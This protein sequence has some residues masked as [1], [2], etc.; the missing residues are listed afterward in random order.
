MSHKINYNSRAGIIGIR[1][2]GKVPL[3]EFRDIYFQ[4]V[5]L[6]KEKDCFLF[7]S[8][9]RNATTSHLTLLEISTLPQTLSEIAARAGIDAKRLKRAI[10][11]APKD[12]ATSLF[13]QGVTLSQ[14]QNAKM[15]QDIAEARKWLSEVGETAKVA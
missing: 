1:V 4:A 5:Q 12:A 11:V 14:G 8:D 10:V 3:D 9:F 7:L 13:A 15:F 6:A 2:Q